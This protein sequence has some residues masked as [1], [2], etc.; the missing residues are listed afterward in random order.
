MR[1]IPTLFVEKD[2]PVYMELR[3][4]RWL[5]R[6]A[7]GHYVEPFDYGD[8]PPPCAFCDEP[9]CLATTF[10]LNMHYEADGTL[11]LCSPW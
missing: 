8:G 10:F 5:F 9:E 6:G 2:S 4:E 7:C 3:G 11:A 1:E